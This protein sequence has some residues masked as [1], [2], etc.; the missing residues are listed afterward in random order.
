MFCYI[1]NH[2][3][4]IQGRGFARSPFGD[5]MGEL[6]L[7]LYA[8]GEGG[9]SEDERI[10]VAATYERGPDWYIATELPG[11]RLKKVADRTN[12]FEAFKGQ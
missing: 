4:E 8:R 10:P 11:F 1:K 3:D 9:Q 6:T 5:S 12:T 2:T 7:S